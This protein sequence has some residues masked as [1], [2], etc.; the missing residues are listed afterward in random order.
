MPTALVGALSM[1]ASNTQGI[2]RE[3]MVCAN[4]IGSDLGRKITPIGRLATL[5]WLHVLAEKNIKISWGYYFRVGA[6][7]RIYAVHSPD[8]A[9]L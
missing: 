4:L 7:Q 9:I 3:A 2:G 6:T 5:F 8:D 1:D